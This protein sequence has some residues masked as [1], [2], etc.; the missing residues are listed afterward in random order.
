MPKDD[1]QRNV[2]DAG[3]MT[4]S[5]FTGESETPASGLDLRLI[6]IMWYVP[7]KVQPARAH[8]AAVG[9]CNWRFYRVIDCRK[10]AGTGSFHCRK[11]RIRILGSW[12]KKCDYAGLSLNAAMQF[13]LTLFGRI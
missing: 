9:S 5:I 4:L 13:S 2:A 6:S 3:K 10:K 8:V 11:L 1:M 12:L 7:R